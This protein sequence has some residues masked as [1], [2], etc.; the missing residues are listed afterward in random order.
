MDKTS[1][2]ESEL[3]LSS[4]VLLAGDFSGVRLSFLSEELCRALAEASESTDFE[5]LRPF[6]LS[7]SD[8]V[9]WS[10]LLLLAGLLR[11]DADPDEDDRD[12]LLETDAFSFLVDDFSEPEELSLFAG[13]GDRLTGEESSSRGLSSRGGLG[14]R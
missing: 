8:D 7:S 6:P 3:L 10:R 2:S 13:D 9:E 5:R 11:G 4:L 12:V 1:R 14:I